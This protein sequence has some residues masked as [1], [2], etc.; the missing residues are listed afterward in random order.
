MSTQSTSTQISLSELIQHTLHNLLV[1][2]QA[3]M[4]CVCMYR[5]DVVRMDIIAHITYDGEL[6]SA[7]THQ[8]FQE[9]LQGLPTAGQARLIDEEDLQGTD[10]QSALLFPLALPDELVG[11]L[12]IV[13]RRAH[14]FQL[15]SVDDLLIQVNTVRAFVENQYLYEAFSQNM[16]VM[17]TMRQIAQTIAEGALPQ[18]VVNIL[19]DNLFDSHVTSCAIMFYGPLREDRPYGPFDYLEMRGSWSKRRGSGIALGTRIYLKQYP[20]LIATLN[21]GEPLVLPTLTEFSSQLDPFMRSL[22]RAERVAS[23]TI[24]PLYAGKHRLGVLLIATNKPHRFSHQEIRNYHL[25]AELL[26]F[27]AISQVLQQHHDLVLQGRFALLEAVTDSVVMV[28][29]D[30]VGARVLTANQRFVRHFGLSDVDVEGLPLNDLL[31]K[32]RIP[33]NLREE[34]GQTWESISV[35]DPAIQHGD[36]HF[37]HEDGRHLDMEW[38][39]APVYQNQHVMGRIY[40]F[41]DVTAERTANRLRSTFLS[42]ISHELRT[43]LTSIQGFAEFILEVNGDDLPDLARE[44][45]EIILKSAHHL[46]KIFSDMI[47]MSRADAGELPLNMGSVHLPDVIIDAIAQL[48]L[49]YKQRKQAVIMELDDD[50]PPV[51]ADADRITQVLNNLLTN[52]IK[53]SPEEGKILVRTDYITSLDELPADTTPGAQLPA[54]QVSVI[55][56]GPGLNTEDLQQVF[57]PFFRAP[58]VRDQQIEGT[59]LGLAVSRSIVEMHRG[60]LWAEVST[61]DV[62]GGIFRFILP[63]MNE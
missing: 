56:E 44:Y 21:S 26:S 35:R 38:Y 12:A 54:I 23:M 18:S 10:Y 45:V 34:L 55:D 24:L 14:A 49:Q 2:T 8:R 50:L 31:K 37:V 4:I 51:Y 30:A 29:P 11:M 22:L 28:L 52:A 16:M 57:M 41:H 62:S 3:D 13:S 25:I 7:A 19:R 60:H 5:F 40:L 47:D 32:M 59:G 20:D 33:N 43:P 61:P 63:V 1:A 39:S 58:K 42:H 48:E 6:P 27:T 15:E 17:Q 9:I 46:R 36:F 53:Y